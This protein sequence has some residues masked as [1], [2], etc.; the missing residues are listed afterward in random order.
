M[1]KVKI[2]EVA[3]EL[4]MNSQEVL[5]KAIDFGLAVKSAQ[6][7]IDSDQAVALME[8]VMSGGTK[9]VKEQPKEESREQI[10]EDPKPTAKI[11]QPK[12]E[13]KPSTKI[14][15]KKEPTPKET[16]VQKSVEEPKE[17]TKII[18]ATTQVQ[19]KP[20]GESLAQIG[21]AHV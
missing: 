1:D 15:A 21:R 2:H 3:K 18:P 13:S 6:S 7:T 12:E 8:S 14:V 4:A 11:E 20:Q 17:E 10:K 5:E 16:V 19:E 9:E